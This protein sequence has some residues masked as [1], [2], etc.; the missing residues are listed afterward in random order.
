MLLE[1][2]EVI[3]SESHPPIDY[4]I[5]SLVS[6][7]QHDY[8]PFIRSCVKR[9]KL[10]DHF[11]FFWAKTVT[12]LGVLMLK[13]NLCSAV[14][15]FRLKLSKSFVGY[16]WSLLFGILIFH[17]VAMLTLGDLILKIFKKTFLACQPLILSL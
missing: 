16:R 9:G 15:R 14:E 4:L 13:Y 10:K 5:C 17:I 8:T 6:D 7:E 3:F 11:I 12:G 1:H 2:F